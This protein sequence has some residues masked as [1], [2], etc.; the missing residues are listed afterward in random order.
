MV[1]DKWFKFFH[2]LFIQQDSLFTQLFELEVVD[3]LSLVLELYTLFSHP[4]ELDSVDD[5]LLVGQ[6]YLNDWVPHVAK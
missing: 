5:P 4:L 2:S 3:N 1:L 6:H